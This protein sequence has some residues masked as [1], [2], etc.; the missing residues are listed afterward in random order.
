MYDPDRLLCVTTQLSFFGSFHPP[1]ALLAY[2]GLG[3]DFLPYFAALLS[4]IGAA[5]IAVVQW[6]IVALL[7]WLRGKRDRL[8]DAET[9][10]AAVSPAERGTGCDETL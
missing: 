10:A 1:M 3:P 2:V 9:Q 8:D 7:G 6:P 4:L 5:L